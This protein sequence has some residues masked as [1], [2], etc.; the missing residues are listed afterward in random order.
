MKTVKL[1]LMTIGIGLSSVLFYSCLDDDDAYSLGD[2][3]IDIA[4]VVPINE[5]TYFLRMDDG[6]TLWPAATDA[7]YYKPKENQRAMV[8][9]TILGDSADGYDHWIKVN[10]IDEILTKEIAENL[11]AKNDSVY[12]TDPVEIAGIWTGDNYL[13]IYFK[14][15]FGGVKKHFVNLIRSKEENVT[16]EFRH[17][18]YDDPETGYLQGGLVAFDLSKH[19]TPDMYPPLDSVTLIIKVKT[20]D[21]DKLYNV[22]F[23]TGSKAVNAKYLNDVFHEGLK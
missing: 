12:G 2:F 1:F 18:A 21:G 4:T 17:N 6:T 10:R 22:K 15:D 7:P 14:A 5:T 20:F 3:W 23:A 9:F 11:E 16:Y 13:N 19:A 8:N